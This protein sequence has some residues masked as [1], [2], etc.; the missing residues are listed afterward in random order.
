MTYHVFE[1]F[2][3]FLNELG[4]DD[5]RWNEV[6]P[7]KR[8]KALESLKNLKRWESYGPYKLVNIFWRIPQ[9]THNLFNSYMILQA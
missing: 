3:I 7:S 1:S 6:D 8:T 4:L 9:M 5:K 2:T